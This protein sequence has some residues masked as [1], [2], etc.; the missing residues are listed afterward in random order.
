[1]EGNVILSNIVVAQINGSTHTRVGRKEPSAR[2]H[3]W[4][5]LVSTLKKKER[6]E[7]VLSN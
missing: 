4:L 7:G 6:S 3:F 2:L 5:L 1:M